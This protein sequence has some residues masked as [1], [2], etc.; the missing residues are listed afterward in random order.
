MSPGCVCRSPLQNT[1]GRP[2]WSVCCL[3]GVCVCACLMACTCI[4]MSRGWIP[5]GPLKGPVSNV[6]GKAEVGRP[7]TDPV[8]LEGGVMCRSR[9]VF[10]VFPFLVMITASKM[11]DD[12]LFFSFLLCN[13]LLC[14]NRNAFPCLCVCCAA[15]DLLPC[16]KLTSPDMDFAA[17]STALVI[18]EYLL[19]VITPLTQAPSQHFILAFTAQLESSWAERAKLFARLGFVDLAETCAWMAPSSGR[20]ANYTTLTFPTGATRT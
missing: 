13:T 1:N 14:F 17:S 19:F 10:P 9:P 16:T 5:R 2:E 6:G 7:G 15:Q 8:V 18:A 4:W 3:W 12:T 11:I 20:R